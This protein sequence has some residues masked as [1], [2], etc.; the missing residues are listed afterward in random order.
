[1]T[2]VWAVLG[3]RPLAIV[4]GVALSGCFNPG[5]TAPESATDGSESTDG[6]TMTTAPSSSASASGNPDTSSTE[7]MSS[8]ADPTSSTDP[9]STTDP[10]TGATDGTSTGEVSDCPGG[11]PTPGDAP[12]ILSAVLAQDDTDDVDLGDIDG[13]GHLD[14]INLSRA[15]GSVETFFGD[16]TG[17]FV[18]DG[19][20]VLDVSGY[21]DTVRLRA[22]AD[23]TVD[24][25]VH[26]EGPVELWVVRGDGAGNWPNPQVYDLTYV[27]AIDIADLDGDDILDLAYFGASDLE[28]RLGMATEAYGAPDHYGQNVGWVVRTTDITGDGNIDI[29]GADYNSN[30]LQ[31]YAGLGDGTFQAEPTLVTGATITGVDS[32]HLDG[33]DLVDL[34]V[35]TS[36]DLRVFYGVAG[37][38]VSST[39][40]TVIDNALGRVRAIDVDADGVDDLITEGGTS[41]EVRFAEGNETFSAAVPFECPASIRRLEVGDVN[42]DCV[43][44]I[45]AALGV[46]Q[47]VCLL[48]SDRD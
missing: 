16:G 23:D 34:V 14:L 20:T 19:V 25:F 22:I 26:M 48:V 3:S 45:V 27:R 9:T 41:I 28:V 18:S 30:E 47:D 33:N 46:A 43:P 21:P 15:D 32:G 35:T 2:R 31:I 40:G 8:T 24:L 4:G 44:D 38:G 13:D 17:D 5:G 11:A 36:D 12:Y 39:P 42:E 1:M 7:T 37:G 10:T 6:V 29:L